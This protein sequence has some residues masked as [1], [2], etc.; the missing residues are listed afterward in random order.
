MR[1]RDRW[2]L[3]TCVDAPDIQRRNTPVVIKRLHIEHGVELQDVTELP[4]I[5][6][7]TTNHPDKGPPPADPTAA[8]SRSLAP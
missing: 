1:E 7:T 2:G 8:T 6:G 4:C 3:G 5:P